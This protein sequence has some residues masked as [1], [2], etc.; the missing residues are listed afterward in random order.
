VA[1]KTTALPKAPAKTART[2]P[3]ILP[4]LHVLALTLGGHG[5][6]FC[7]AKLPITH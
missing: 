4:P 2:Y 6:G 7:P 3:K 1:T 5:K